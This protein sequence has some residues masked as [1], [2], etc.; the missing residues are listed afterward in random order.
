MVERFNR[1]LKQRLFRALTANATLKYLDFLPA[2]VKGYNASMHNA[3][4]MAPKNVTM[5][6]D[7]QVWKKL[8]SKKLLGVPA[9]RKRSPKFKVGDEVMLS[10]VQCVFKKGYLPGW[11]EEIFT[12]DRILEENYVDIELEMAKKF[13]MIE[14][15]EKTDPTTGQK[16]KELSL[17]G[18]ARVE[19]FRD[20]NLR[21]WTNTHLWK[22]VTRH[23]KTYMRFYSYVN[24]H[25]SGLNQ[26][27]YESSFDPNRTLFVYTDLAQTQIVGSTETDL[28][29]EVVFKNN[30][31]GKYL[32]EPINLQY[33]PIQ[34]NVFDE[35]EVGISETDGTQTNFAQGPT[36]LTVHF[37][38]RGV[39]VEK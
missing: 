25:F 33:L 29:R 32:F 8:Y 4:G 23:G 11:T 34:K 7:G 3:I 17:A 1:T 24:W 30:Q 16:T 12:V 26:Q 21:R 13:H 9:A 22:S 28:L 37:R 38:K 14:E 27:I 5:Y 31:G 10:K 39:E 20:Y 19:H 6:N 15:L 18:S 2:L 35:V 36:I